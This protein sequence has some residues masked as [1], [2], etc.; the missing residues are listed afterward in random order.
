MTRD[1]SGEAEYTGSVRNNTVAAKSAGAPLS[2]E[3]QMRL[4]KL[5]GTTDVTAP[6][7]YPYSWR[8]E[9]HVANNRGPQGTQ[10]LPGATG[11]QGPTGPQGEP[12]E[13]GPI[14]PTGP[15]GAVGPEGPQ[16]PAGADGAPTVAAARLALSNLEN[17]TAGATSILIASDPSFVTTGVIPGTDIANDYVISPGWTETDPSG[18]LATGGPAFGCRLQGAGLWTVNM[19]V[20][21]ARNGTPDAPLQVF[22]GCSPLGWAETFPQFLA[23]TNIPPM[24][25]FIGTANMSFWTAAAQ[26]EVTIGFVYSGTNAGWYDITEVRADFQRLQF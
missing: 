26:M 21:G 2:A 22:I 17:V 6:S 4:M 16:G 10:G 14:G 9:V 20:P 12:G 7:D 25:D 8:G 13:P 15:Q 23:R 11:P 5:T 18:I 24:D 19:Q 1:Y 3:E